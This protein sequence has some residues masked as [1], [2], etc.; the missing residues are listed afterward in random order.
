MR[1]GRDEPGI[2]RQVPTRIDHLQGVV[3][4]HIRDTLIPAAAEQARISIETEPISFLYY[5]RLEFGR[6][7]SCWKEENTEEDAFCDVCYGTGI[8]TGFKKWGCEWECLDTTATVSSVNIAPNF[9]LDVRPVPYT[10][11]KD[12]VYGWMEWTVQLKPNI[13][14][15]DLLKLDASQPKGAKVRVFIRGA[16]EESF[17][18][19]TSGSRALVEAKLAERYLVF[20]IEI[21][22]PPKGKSPRVGA[23]HF[24]Y[25]T[26]SDISVII[27][28]PRSE[29]SITLSDMGLYDSWQSQQM[30]FGK[31]LPDVSTNDFFISVTDGSRWKITSLSPFN[32]MGTLIGYSAN[33]RLVQ[34]TES[35][36][37]VP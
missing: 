34:R 33:A 5:K 16:S 27:N 21:S 29:K 18:E 8:P 13:G 37:R 3:T 12:T 2:D 14:T 11:V 10:L 1:Y 28:T 9:G 35:Y 30:E 24:R 17:T 31:E 15:I 6:V 23:L 36:A 20:R 19:L 7:C 22:R 4:Q 32:P 26:R 25:R